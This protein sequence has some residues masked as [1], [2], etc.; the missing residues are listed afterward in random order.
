MP[1]NHPFLAVDSQ[2]KPAQVCQVC[3]A[4]G[5]GDPGPRSQEK[6]MESSVNID[7]D[8]DDADGIIWY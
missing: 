6:F 5:W 3:R 4:A 1:L 8:I 2:G 7:D